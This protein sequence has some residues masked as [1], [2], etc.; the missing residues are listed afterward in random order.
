MKYT[1]LFPPGFIFDYADHDERLYLIENLVS[2]LGS[3]RRTRL[4][5]R[6]DHFNKTNFHRYIDGHR[7]IV[8]I[9]KTIY[10]KLI[11]GYS[12]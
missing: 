4:L 12:E 2:Y 11:A 3:I 6:Y 5:F 9:I 7:N 10:G 8:I 1:H